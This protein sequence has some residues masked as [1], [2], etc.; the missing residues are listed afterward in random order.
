[1]NRILSIILIVS[2]SILLFFAQSAR[3]IN[4]QIFN[5]QNFTNSVLTGIQE[6][7]S[8]R[9]IAAAVVDKTLAD[10]PLVR[11]YAG[12]RLVAVTAGL[13]DSDLSSQALRYLTNDLYA[14]VTAP[15]RKDVAINLIAIKEPLAQIAELAR[16]PETAEK[17]DSLGENIPD[18]VT[19]LR[20][21]DV[22]DLSGTVSTL[23]WLSPL[24]WLGSLTL[25]STYIYFGRRQFARRVYVVGVAVM[26][27][28]VT[29][30]LTY[31]FVPPPV[32]AA[33]PT[34]E[35]RPVAENL[36]KQFLGSFRAQMAA[37]F[38]YAAVAT[39]LFNQRQNLRTLLT[40]IVSLIPNSSKSK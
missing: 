2:A 10:R 6:E 37:M 34:I 27:V 8:R 3:W 26:V 11:Q 25:F 36:S 38:I 39:L 7:S 5:Q 31:P 13:L 21:N 24:L 1:M 33:I 18:T 19:V 16:N 4:H 14:Y 17:I 28:A 29:G 22:P 9:A 20:S 35:L 23:L 12:E 32:M 30:V 40:K 15:N